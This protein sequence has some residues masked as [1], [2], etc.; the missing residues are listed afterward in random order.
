MAPL[1]L[2]GRIAVAPVAAA[3]DRL[4]TVPSV[5]LQRYAGTWHE[6]ARLPNRFQ[7]QC[8]TEVTATYTPRDDGTVDVVNRCRTQSGTLDAAGRLGPP[9]RRARV[10]ARTRPRGRLPGRPRDAQRATPAAAAAGEVN[11]L[12]DPAQAPR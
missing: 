11:A 5:V 12:D 10:T 6:I 4:F 2:P 1:T 8:A 3:L 7:A 9:A